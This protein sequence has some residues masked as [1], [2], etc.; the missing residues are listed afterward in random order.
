M[1]LLDNQPCFFFGF[2][3]FWLVFCVSIYCKSIGNGEFGN[4]EREKGNAFFTAFFLQRNLSRAAVWRTW[5]LRFFEK[6]IW[7]KIIFFVGS[8]ST[9]LYSTL[10]S[11]F[12]LRG[13]GGAF[14]SK[15]SRVC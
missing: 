7:F 3:V 10:P 12:G 6:K 13:G 1:F 8:G 15:V 4:G 9:L 14:L 2:S 5:G 11:G